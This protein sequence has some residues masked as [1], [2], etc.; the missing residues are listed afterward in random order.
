M[1]YA[2]LHGLTLA[3]QHIRSTHKFRPKG[4]VVLT[5]I[6][7]RVANP[8]TRPLQQNAVESHELGDLKALCACAHC[9]NEKKS[10]AIAR[11][12]SENIQF[13]PGWKGKAGFDVD[14]TFTSPHCNTGCVCNCAFVLPQMRGDTKAYV[15]RFLQECLHST[16]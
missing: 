6:I 11:I 7:R 5:L 8:L 15:L 4:P 13:F 16:R 3:F 2:L 1:P 9:R 12:L 14:I 10:N